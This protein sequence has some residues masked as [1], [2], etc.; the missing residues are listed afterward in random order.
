M[1]RLL[2]I[3]NLFAHCLF[4]ASTQTD[5]NFIVLLGNSGN[6]KSFFANFLL[7]EGSEEFYSKQCANS[8][9][10]RF[11]AKPSLFRGWQVVDT[12]ALDSIRQD[13]FS[14]PN[15]IRQALLASKGKYKLC[16]IFS[17]RGGRIEPQDIP[18]LK[19]ILLAIRDKLPYYILVNLKYYKRGL[20][21]EEDFKAAM[22]DLIQSKSK[23]LPGLRPPE[24][25]LFFPEIDEKNKQ[26][27]M[28]RWRN[29]VSQM[30]SGYITSVSDIAE[31]SFEAKKAAREKLQNDPE[32]DP[33]VVFNQKSFGCVIQ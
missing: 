3:T 13:V 22:S 1:F 19:L 29:F 5:E 31:I 4:S 9:T 16:F 20:I 6:G 25:Y 12:P 8:I 18:D 26:E 21:V 28:E 10:T 23:T 11:L 7:P 32:D 15:E 30:K 24:D 2:L 33:H 14:A 17:H 27:S